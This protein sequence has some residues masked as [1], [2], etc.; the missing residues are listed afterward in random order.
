MT[1]QKR[2]HRVKAIIGFWFG[3]GIVSASAASL[4]LA[5]VADT[6]LQSAYPTNNF[7][8]DSSFQAGGRRYPG[9]ARGLLQFD[10]AGAVPAGAT[11]DSVSLTLTVTRTPSGGASSVFDLHRVLESWGEGNNSGRGGMP[12]DL[13]ETDWNVRFAPGTP[14][15]TPG[16]TF[17]ATVSAA[18]MI[19][20]DGSYTFASTGSLVSDVQLWLNDPSRNFGWELISER[21]N[22]QTTIRRFGSRDAG[23]AAP[24]LTISYTP[25]PEPGT[26]T[27]LG[28]GA[29]GLWLVLWRRMMRQSAAEG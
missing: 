28:T 24:V 12:A 1:P 15:H 20:G 16:G 22:I 5:P 8:A 11:I 9:V 21:E 3:L 23:A 10:I 18:Q 4:T 2:R 29:L 13:N 19:G 6:T 25:I 26:V 14:W 27:L 17:L 7:G